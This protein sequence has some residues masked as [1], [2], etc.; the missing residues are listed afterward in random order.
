MIKKIFENSGDSVKTL[1]KTLFFVCL[2]IAIFALLI[3]LSLIIKHDYLSLSELLKMQEM[4]YIDSIYKDYRF[5]SEPYEGLRLI[6]LSLFVALF[7]LSLIPLYAF[8][9]LVSSI[10]LIK[11]S[12]RNINNDLLDYDDKLDNLPEL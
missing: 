2:I 1:A 7:S 10:Q 4:E 12:M 11:Q 5:I 8:G 9:E 6:K 3:G